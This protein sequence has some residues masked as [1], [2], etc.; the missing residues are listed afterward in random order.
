MKLTGH[1]QCM[2]AIYVFPGS[3]LY[4]C[5]CSDP[6]LDERVNLQHCYV[7]GLPGQVCSGAT[8]L[9]VVRD[10]PFDVFDGKLMVLCHSTFK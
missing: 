7:A 8:S 1:M 5:N 10:V 9:V 3:C 4:Q 6:I 2:C